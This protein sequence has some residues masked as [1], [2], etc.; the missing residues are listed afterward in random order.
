M[1]RRA[2]PTFFTSA[3]GTPRVL[4]VGLLRGDPGSVCGELTMSSKIPRVV[5]ASH[6]L[7]NNTFYHK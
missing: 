7:P 2:A 5:L 4:L 1:G 3:S 6:M